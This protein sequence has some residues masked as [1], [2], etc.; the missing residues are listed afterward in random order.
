MTRTDTVNQIAHAS[1]PLNNRHPSDAGD[2]ACAKYLSCVLYS[3]THGG[4]W[5][6]TDELQT[7]LTDHHFSRCFWDA[8]L[9]RREQTH[10]SH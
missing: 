5:P 6:T 4:Q 8:E 1:I 7:Y 9:T 2:L 3:H 10:E